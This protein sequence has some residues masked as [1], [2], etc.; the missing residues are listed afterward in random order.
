MK[1]TL[2]LS[3]LVL[4]LNSFACEKMEAQFVGFVSAVSGI[5]ETG[6]ELSIAFDLYNEH[7]FCP[8]LKEDVLNKK[9]FADASTCKTLSNT[10]M[11]GILSWDI[12]SDKISIEL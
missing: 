11:G 7:F 1:L 3:L 2:I 4:S 9:I 12:E 5:D 8:L 6:C 10:H